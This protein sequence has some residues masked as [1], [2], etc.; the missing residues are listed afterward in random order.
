MPIKDNI[1]DGLG[2]GWLGWS[3]LPSFG[4][5]QMRIK[6]LGGVFIFVRTL[7]Q[8][9]LVHFIKAVFQYHSL[10]LQVSAYELTA[11]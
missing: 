5:D 4:A 9:H 2:V 11:L 6:Y 7:A 10:P 3:G 8:K 1:W